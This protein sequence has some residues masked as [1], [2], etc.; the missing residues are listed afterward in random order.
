MRAGWVGLAGTGP[1]RWL[2]IRRCWGDSAP[3]PG[4]PSRSNR[5]AVRQ[6][7]SRPGRSLPRVR[8]APRRMPVPARCP[9]AR[10][11]AL[12]E[13]RF[14]PAMQ[15]V[16]IIGCGYT[17]RRLAERLRT[18]GACVRGFA[19]RVESLRQIEEVGAEALPLDLDA[20]MTPV[21]FTGHLVY[22]AV[23]PARQAG[24]PRLDR[25]LVR[26]LGQSH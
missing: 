5:S 10:P 16:S 18:S 17:G 23:P 15:P 2:S 4:A 11:S 9:S 21:D 14:D 6:P 22:Y 13:P 20:A 26:L 3:P 19:T 1:L 8:S 24:D 25:F 12:I 7:D